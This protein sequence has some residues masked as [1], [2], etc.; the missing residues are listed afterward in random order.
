MATQTPKHALGLKTLLGKRKSRVRPVDTAYSGPVVILDEGNPSEVPPPAPTPE[1]PTALR[2]AGG[3]VGHR[4]G[5][6]AATGWDA[7]RD[8]TGAQRQYDRVN[9]R[10][11]PTVFRRQ[12]SIVTCKYQ[13]GTEWRFR[14]IGVIA[15]TD[16]LSLKAHE[17]ATQDGVAKT[18]A[19]YERVS[20]DTAVESSTMTTTIRWDATTSEFVYTITGMNTVPAGKRAYLFVMPA[21]VSSATGTPLSTWLRARTSLV[22]LVAEVDAAGSPQSK[23]ADKRTTI[24]TRAQTGEAD[25]IK[26]FFAMVLVGPEFTETNKWALL[27]S[28]NEFTFPG[29][30]AYVTL[31]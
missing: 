19:A 15:A 26:T 13:N 18:G 7:P 14:G 31:P 11:A 10:T 8:H 30:A 9:D 17:R 3:Y 20:D 22:R 12:Y 29:L 23:L 6:V 4:F 21:R 5:Y 1:H 2:R 24:T 16:G 28:N 27:E 25:S